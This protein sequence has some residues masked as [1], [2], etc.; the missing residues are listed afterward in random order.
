MPSRKLA[1][2]FGLTVEDLLD[3]VVDDVAVVPGKS[4]DEAGDVVTA[5]D[6]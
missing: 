2:L 1:D 6:G 3:E 4:G 5:L